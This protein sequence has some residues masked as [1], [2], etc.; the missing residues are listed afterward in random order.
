[1]RLDLVHDGRPIPPQVIASEWSFW[2]HMIRSSALISRPIR[3][4]HGRPGTD[5]AE[6]DQIVPDPAGQLQP[7]GMV[8]QHQQHLAAL[9]YQRHIGTRGGVGHPMGIAGDVP[10]LAVLNAG[11]DPAPDALHTLLWCLPGKRSW[12]RA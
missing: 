12:I 3:R 11:G 1:M 10:G 4:P 5:R 7:P 2:V 8:G 6:M 9:Q